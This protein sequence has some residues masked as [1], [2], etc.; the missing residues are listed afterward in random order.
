MGPYL[1]PLPPLSWL[2]LSVGLLGHRGTPSTHLFSPMTPPS[3]P[4]P[5]VLPSTHS[6][7]SHPAPPTLH[8]FLCLPCPSPWPDPPSPFPGTPAVSLPTPFT[9]SR[10]PHLPPECPSASWG[11]AAIAALVCQRPTYRDIAGRGRLARQAISNSRSSISPGALSK[12]FSHLSCIRITK[13]GMGVGASRQNNLLGCK[14][15][16]P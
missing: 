12:G 9:G 16:H 14:N 5:S 11:G 2:S 7:C 6:P 10:H 3:C 15:L 8:L 4:A 13:Q 1:R